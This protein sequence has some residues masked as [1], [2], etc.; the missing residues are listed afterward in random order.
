MATYTIKLKRGQS[1]SWTNLNP[2]LAPG[3]P[4]FE[5]D[6][7]RL[8]IGNGVDAWNKLSYVGEQDSPSVVNEKTSADFPATGNPEVI[9][10]AQ[11]EKMLYQWNPSTLRYEPL[12]QGSS[13]GGEDFNDIVL[14]HGGNALSY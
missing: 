8:K 13:G 1:S 10:K 4:G 5:L 6:T 9:Y 3:E 12:N 2:V 7:G 14:I 11:E